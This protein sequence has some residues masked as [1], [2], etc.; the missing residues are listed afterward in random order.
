MTSGDN[1]GTLVYKDGSASFP[2]V[3]E[4]ETVYGSTNRDVIKEADTGLEDTSTDFSTLS[5]CVVDKSFQFQSTTLVENKSATTHHDNDTGD[6]DKD[7]QSMSALKD[8]IHKHKPAILDCLNPSDLFG[9]L[10]ELGL[11]DVWEDKNKSRKELA[12]IVLK[13][14]EKKQAYCDFLYSIEEDRDNMGHHYIACLLRGEQFAREEDMEESSRLHRRMK[15]VRNIVKMIN[16]DALEPYLVREGLVTEDEQDRLK[17]PANTMQDKAKELLVLLKR[18]GPT[19]HSI[20]VHKC[21]ALEGT[22]LSHKEIHD[23]LLAGGPRKRKGST[24]TYSQKTKVPKSQ[25]LLLELPKGI[26]NELYFKEIREMRRCHLIGKEK[27]QEAED[28]YERC[29]ACPDNPVEMKIALL[30]ESCTMYI[31][32]N[33]PEVVQERVKQA[34][35]KCLELEFS[36]SQILEGRCEWVLAKLYRYVRDY[37]KA[38]QHIRNAFHYHRNCEQGE[39]R[40]LTNYCHACILLSVESSSSRDV[41]TAISDLNIAIKSASEKKYGLDTSH[42]KI[43]FAQANVGS[44]SHQPPGTSKV[45]SVTD[46]QRALEEITEKDLQPR[47]RCMYHYTWSDVYR[48]TGQMDNAKQS[49]ELALSI[50]KQHDFKTEIKSSEIRLKP[51]INAA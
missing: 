19:A 23:S 35:L 30:L 32:D 10:E 28:I 45:H 8:K 21:L 7:K 15:D 12:E 14:V 22:H 36:N 9:L 46:A 25:P 16:V 41:E 40:A 31:T 17:R 29:M 11:D 39:D 24:S 26:T 4:Q 50:A 44:S 51:L 37:T 48:T 18:K 38:D 49:A 13:E 33:Q 1:P 47:T 42:C 43:R 6:V 27:W 5:S 20:L 34:R 3:R 2:S